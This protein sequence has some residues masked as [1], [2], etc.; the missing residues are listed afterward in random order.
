[1]NV[2]LVSI[3]KRIII[4]DVLKNDYLELGFHSKGDFLFALSLKPHKLH[5]KAFVIFFFVPLHS[6][7]GIFGHQGHKR[8]VDNNGDGMYKI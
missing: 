2:L 1:M 8:E 4:H 5:Q 3:L 7:S 6:A